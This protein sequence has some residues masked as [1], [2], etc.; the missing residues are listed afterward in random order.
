MQDYS[1]HLT[2]ELIFSLVSP[3]LLL[4]MI[5]VLVAPSEHQIYFP[6]IGILW[7]TWTVGMSEKGAGGRSNRDGINIGGSVPWGAGVEM[8]QKGHIYL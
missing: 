4:K 1:D 7:D 6:C 2:G 8:F 3:K 5:L